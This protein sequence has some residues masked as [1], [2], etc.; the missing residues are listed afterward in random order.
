MHASITY[1]FPRFL[2]QPAIHFP[3]HPLDDIGSVGGGGD[4]SS[5]H[6]N[7]SRSHGG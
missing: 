7:M 5:S 3:D 1:F 2:L 6:V 4:A